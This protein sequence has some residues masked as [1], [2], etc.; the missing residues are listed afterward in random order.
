MPEP[1]EPKPQGES[2]LDAVVAVE[3]TLNSRLAQAREAAESRVQEALAS[4]QQRAVIRRQQIA[5]RVAQSLEEA[6]R[7]FDLQLAGEA[8]QREQHIVQLTAA[9]EPL[10]RSLAARILAEVLGL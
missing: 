9:L 10:Q 6:R 2:T 4:V 7:Q 1:S 3:Q 8:Q 5:E